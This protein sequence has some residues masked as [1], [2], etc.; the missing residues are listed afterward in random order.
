MTRSH[1]TNKSQ[2]VL[3]NR[4]ILLVDDNQADGWLLREAF[5]ILNVP[6]ELQ[7]VDD[8][9]QALKFLSENMPPALILLDINMPKVNGFEVLKAIRADAKL[10]ALPVI[11]FTSSRHRGD[12]EKA[13]HLGANA[14]VTKPA[15]NFID[16]IGDLT[17][18]WLGRVELP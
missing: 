3:A 15:I 5:Q 18:F 10:R 2:T 14:Y 16:T 6:H 8:G 1:R 11:I 17:R 12:V 4:K 7:I 9:E 13:Y